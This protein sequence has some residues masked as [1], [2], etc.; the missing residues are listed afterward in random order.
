MF[1]NLCF[2]LSLGLVA[3]VAVAQEW[4]IYAPGTSFGPYWRDLISIENPTGMMV[5]V[6]LEARHYPSGTRVLFSLNGATPSFEESFTLDPRR[7]IGIIVT[8]QGEGLTSRSL[9]TTLVLKQADG[10]VYSLR[11][12]IWRS[13]DNGDIRMDLKT[14]F[15][16]TADSRGY[17]PGEYTFLSRKSGA[18]LSIGGLTMVLMAGETVKVNLREPVEEIDFFVP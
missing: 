7:Q 2:F 14:P 3:Q 12:L 1:R 9:P 11:T 5:R 15:V 18:V 6:V 4:A 8:G 16:E 13:F 17:P 10:N